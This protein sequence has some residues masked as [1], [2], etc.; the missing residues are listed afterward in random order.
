MIDKALN[1]LLQK[2]MMIFL[3]EY[4]DF[5]S[6]SQ[7]ETLKN[8]EFQNALITGETDNPFGT[9]SLGR[10]CFSSIADELLKKIKSMPN[11]NSKREKLH[12]K[13]MSSYLKY[14]CENGYMVE[15]YY[16]DMLMYFI[17]K[18]VIK[19]DNPFIW[20]LINQETKYLSIKYGLRIAFLYNKEEK[21]ISR[22]T[23]SLKKDAL[24]KI[25]FMDQASSFKY[26]NDQYGFSYANLVY[27]ISKLVSQEFAKVNQKITTFEDFL[28]YTTQ[29]DQLSYIDAYDSI[30]N[31]EV[32][33]SL[34][35]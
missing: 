16:G 7:L 1:E 21:V 31:Y 3:K 11:Y 28:N 30:L 15:D 20:G 6:I 29:Y 24:R 2:Y 33:N 26:L 18:L 14:M 25:I 27:D 12:N 13:N 17:F 22:L 5:L 9:I 4:S 23:S 10:I 35:N 19:E 34:T 8:F 32:Q